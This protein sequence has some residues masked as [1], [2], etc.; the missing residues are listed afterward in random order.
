M[1]LSF[2][3]LDYIIYLHGFAESEKMLCNT[4]ESI[5]ATTKLLELT[6]SCIYVMYKNK[7]I[8]S[9]INYCQFH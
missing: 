3:Q 9:A 8:F 2:F 6:M 5:K 7:R 4:T 1:H